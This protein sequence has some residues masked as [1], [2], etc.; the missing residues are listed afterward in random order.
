M[1]KEGARNTGTEPQ[2][3]LFRRFAAPAA[4]SQ[5]QVG[6]GTLESMGPTFSNLQ[7]GISP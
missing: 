5:H 2:V 3:N 4:S 6:F 1:G 7:H